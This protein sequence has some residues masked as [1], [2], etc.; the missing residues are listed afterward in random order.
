MNQR[1]MRAAVRVFTM[2]LA[3]VFVTPVFAQGGGRRGDG[4]DRGDSRSSARDDRGRRG[5]PPRG[6]RSRGRGHRHVYTRSAPPPQRAED[7]G[8]RPYRHAVWV[9]G[10]WRWD[11]DEYVWTSGR[12]SRSRH[13][14]RYVQPRYVQRNDA[15][16][17]MPGFWVRLE[18]N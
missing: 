8:D 3:L 15:W 5:G 18:V 9:N 4:H 7:R 12:W 11:G 17:V 13:G 2:L 1:T 6:H 16:V 14:Y 10:Y